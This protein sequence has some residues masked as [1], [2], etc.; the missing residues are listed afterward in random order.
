MLHCA[1]DRLAT[2]W[3]WL[4]ISYLKDNKRPRF[5]GSLCES[6]V[7]GTE[8]AKTDISEQKIDTTWSMFY[9]VINSLN[10]ERRLL[11]LKIQSVPRCKHFS[12]RL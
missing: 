1:Y 7:T 2:L 6:C 4:V 3:T 5:Y 12:S 11:Y 8:S 10:K 9:I